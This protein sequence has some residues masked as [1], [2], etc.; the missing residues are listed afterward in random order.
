MFIYLPRIIVKAAP[1]QT[2][3][4][5]IGQNIPSK[6]KNGPRS[7]KMQSLQFHMSRNNCSDTL[8]QNNFCRGK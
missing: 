5:I 2:A 8:I 4:E 7:G 3:L 6:V 1:V